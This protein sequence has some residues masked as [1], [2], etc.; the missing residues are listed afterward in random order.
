MKRLVSIALAVGFLCSTAKAEEV[1]VSEMATYTMGDNDTRIAAKEACVNRAVSQ[2]LQKA[3]GVFVESNLDSTLTEKDQGVKGSAVAR[4]RS[5]SAGVAKVEAEK[6]DTML[7]PE[8]RVVITCSVQVTLDPD[9]AVKTTED[10]VKESEKITSLEERLKKLEE[11][12]AE[13]PMSGQPQPTIEPM[14]PSQYPQNIQVAKTRM[15]TCRMLDW[16]GR[17]ECVETYR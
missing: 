6:V 7:D 10:A 1:T 16:S 9:K 14:Y 11:A 4:T 3:G 8:N 13:A 2:A 5:R 17:R 12:K 15:T